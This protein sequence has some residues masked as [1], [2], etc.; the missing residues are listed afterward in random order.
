MITICI[1]Y[2]SSL[3]LSSLGI[4]SS[5]SDLCCNYSGLSFFIAI[6]LL[7][8]QISSPH[9][10]INHKERKVWVGRKLFSYISF[11]QERHLLST[12]HLPE[13][14]YMLTSCLSTRET[15]QSQLLIEDY[16]DSSPDIS[17]QA[18]FLVA[19]TEIMLT[20][21]KGSDGSSEQANQ[22]LFLA[23]QCTRT[24]S[25]AIKPELETFTV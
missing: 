23:F 18:P 8:Q 14:C 5:V 21:L 7:Q 10:T 11:Y 1:F 9:S 2:P 13:V 12:Y 4:F 16:Y 20:L 24:E 25:R 6:P 3:K 22:V 17:S 19:I 15:M